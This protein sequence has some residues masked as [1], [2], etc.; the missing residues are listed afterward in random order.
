MH[1]RVI[2]VFCVSFGASIMHK[3]SALNLLWHWH[4]VCEHVHLRS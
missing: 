1:E 4:V 3:M 2:L